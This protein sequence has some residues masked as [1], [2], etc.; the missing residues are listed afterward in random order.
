MVELFVRGRRYSERDVN[1]LLAGAFDDYVTIRRYLIDYG[2]LDRKPTEAPIG[3]RTRLI[4]K[5]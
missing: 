1:E 3:E 4:V 5:N 2:F